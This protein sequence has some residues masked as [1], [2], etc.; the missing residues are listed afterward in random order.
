[1]VQNASKYTTTNK[2][3]NTQIRAHVNITQYNTMIRFSCLTDNITVNR[4]Q[5][6]TDIVS[7]IGA[8]PLIIDFCIIAC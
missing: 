3:S 1:M 7:V 8:T 5:W 4:L 2:Y 6:M